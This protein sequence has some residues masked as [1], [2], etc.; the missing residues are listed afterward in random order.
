MRGSKYLAGGLN[1]GQPHI[2]DRCVAVVKEPGSQAGH[3]PCQSSRIPTYGPS[4]RPQLGVSESNSAK[5]PDM[6]QP[7]PST[8]RNSDTSCQ[9]DRS[10]PTIA[11]STP[12]LPVRRTGHTCTPCSTSQGKRRGFSTALGASVSRSG[13]IPPSPERMDDPLKLEPP[14]ILK[15][16]T[17]TTPAGWIQLGN[18]E[19][20]ALSFQDPQTPFVRTNLTHPTRRP[21]P[22]RG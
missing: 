15:R 7:Q 3:H 5:P 8:V 11:W 4:V 6:V 16:D 17:I 1:G 12:P 20:E 9:P 21:A 2:V 22:R 18:K 10:T 19:A 13:L 14:E